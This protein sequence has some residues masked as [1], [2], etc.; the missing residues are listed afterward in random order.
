MDFEEMRQ[1]LFIQL[2]DK[3]DLDLK[4]EM[5]AEFTSYFKSAF[6]KAHNVALFYEYMK[7][8]QKEKED[9]VVDE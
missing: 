6:M 7:N 5:I 4:G 3:G 1:R 9:R 8:K 2:C